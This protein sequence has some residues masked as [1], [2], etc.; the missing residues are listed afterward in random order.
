[1]GAP[2]SAAVLTR[3]GYVVRPFAPEDYGIVHEAIRAAGGPALVNDPEE[4]G[5][6]YRHKG[7]AWT[8]TFDGRVLG[9]AGVVI[10]WIGCGVAWLVM[11]PEGRENHPLVAARLVRRLLPEAARGLR[12]LEADVLEG[13]EAGERLM[14]WLGFEKESRMPQ[15]GPRGEAF[16]KWAFFPYNSSIVDD[17]PRETRG[18]CA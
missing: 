2:V 8:A 6:L 16:C 11:T 17:V 9:C 13:W 15:Y 1:M 14:R 10:N 18:R 4:M 3:T 5:R 12:R 7:P